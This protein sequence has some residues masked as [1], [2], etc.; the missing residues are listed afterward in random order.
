MSTA[1]MPHIIHPLS[2]HVQWQASSLT[3]NILHVLRKLHVYRVLYNVL[4]MLLHI[5]C[6]V[7]CYLYSQDVIERMLEAESEKGRLEDEKSRLEKEKEYLVKQLEAKSKENADMKDAFCKKELEAQLSA[8]TLQEELERAQNVIT[9]REKE[10][11]DV[12]VQ[13]QQKEDTLNEAMNEL[14][15]EEQLRKLRDDYDT[16]KEKGK[17]EAKEEYDALVEQMTRQKDQ[18]LQALAKEKEQEIETARQEGINEAKQQY[19]AE[20]E[21]EKAKMLHD[22]TLQHDETLKDTV[23][24]KV[25]AALQKLHAHVLYP[26]GQDPPP[27]MGDENEQ[28]TAILEAIKQKEQDA[29]TER[30]DLESQLEKF[31]ED[32]NDIL[33][34]R[35]EAINNKDKEIAE[36][37]TQLMQIKQEQDDNVGAFI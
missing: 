10:L 33:I 17:K 3:Y 30:Q 22:I 13:L 36:L 15:S 32:H 24:K 9:E 28:V 8:G 21:K 19:D 11:A 37:K 5:I 4:C 26:D 27:L 20:F 35:D 34:K 23:A 14:A 31:Q 2:L 29:A 7:P 6:T 1:Y 16:A 18:L 25:E 12:N